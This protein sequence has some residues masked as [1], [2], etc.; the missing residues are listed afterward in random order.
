MAPTAVVATTVIP[1]TVVVAVAPI[2]SVVPIIVSIS[3][4]VIVAVIRCTVVIRTGAVIIVRSVKNRER[5][6]Q[7]EGKVNTSASRRF[8]EERQSRD[9]QQEDNELLHNHDIGRICLRI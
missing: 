4:V 7:P 3:R 9:N 5:N 6:W 8:G 2:R 1:M